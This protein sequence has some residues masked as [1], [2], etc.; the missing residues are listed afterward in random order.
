MKLKKREG[1]MSMR[2][3]YYY[4]IEKLNSLINSANYA[5]FFGGAGVSTD[6]G[7]PDFRGNGGL[8]TTAVFDRPTEYYLS[9]ACLVR[10]PELFFEFYKQNMLYPDAKPNETHF[11][12]ARLEAE[13][14]LRAVI[15]QNIDGLHTSAGSKNV[16]EV[17]GNTRR[18]YCDRCGK[19][20]APEYVI[21]S[22][23]VPE[24]SCCGGVVRPDVTLYGEGLDGRQFSLAEEEIANADLLIVGG[25]SLTVNPAA[26]LVG[27]FEGEHLVIINLSPTPYDV[28]AELVINAPLAEV[29]ACID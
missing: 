10:E 20:F 23:G 21:E 16:I 24:C 7:I 25:T 19:L 4:E 12:L 26:S 9:R 1:G 6:S 28:F 2:E 27:M 8:Y 15:T 13:G 29:F 14:K 3:E 22:R 17:H 11:A 5:V 18:C